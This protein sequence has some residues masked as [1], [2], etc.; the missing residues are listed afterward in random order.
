MNRKRY[1]RHLLSIAGLTTVLSSCAPGITQYR[2]EPVSGD[3]ARIDGRSTTKAEQNGIGVVA[4]FEHEDM[5]FVVFDIEVK[6]KTDH[7]IMVNPS[8]F[9]YTLL[10]VAQDTLRM[11]QQ[12]EFLAVQHAVDPDY[13][14]SQV[15][16]RQKKEEKRLKTAKVINTVLFAAILIS[17]ASSSGKS[18][19]YGEW[20]QK[21]I[22]HDL[23]WQALNVK[24]AVDYGTHANRMQKYDQESYRWQ[25][26]ALKSTQVAAGESVRGF[27]YV[28]KNPEARYLNLV[29][30]LPEEAAVPITFQQELVTTRGNKARH[31]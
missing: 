14:A 5:E 26:M 27:I 3:V 24:R 4:S 8:D 23:A 6:N 28:R 22:N 25:A 18:R 7:A 11:Q 29:Y 9:Q 19:N 31:R 12:N 15:A 17:D 2:L 1:I 20:R 13:A 30:T 10:N 21:R 16:F